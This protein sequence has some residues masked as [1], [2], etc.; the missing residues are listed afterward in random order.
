MSKADE[1]VK[2]KAL[3]SGVQ[4]QG[5]GEKAQIVYSSEVFSSGQHGCIL[6]MEE[7]DNNR[8]AKNGNLFLGLVEDADRDKKGYGYGVRACL[9]S[10]N[11]Q[12]MTNKNSGTN[13]AAYLKV[14]VVMTISRPTTPP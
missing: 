14:T 2:V 8:V 1:S 9:F 11:G 5:A 13:F 10:T 3:V 7:Y 4:Y 12:G 6:M